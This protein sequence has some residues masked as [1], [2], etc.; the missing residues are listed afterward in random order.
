[1]VTALRTPIADPEQVADV[2]EE[3]VRFRQVPDVEHREEWE[4]AQDVRDAASDF[5]RSRLG[6]GPCRLWQDDGSERKTGPG[7]L[8]TI[9]TQTDS[10]E[11]AIAALRAAYGR[12]SQA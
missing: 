3:L 10:Y 4:G 9:D 5:R 7:V 11:Q 8:L 6:L 1:V 12:G 2:A